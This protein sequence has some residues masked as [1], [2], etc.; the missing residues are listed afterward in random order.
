[1][2]WKLE[3]LLNEKPVFYSRPGIYQYNEDAISFEIST[4]QYKHGNKENLS[5]YSFPLFICNG[6]I[7]LGIYVIKLINC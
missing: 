1:M 6:K 3:F 2:F 7:L 4:K 5:I